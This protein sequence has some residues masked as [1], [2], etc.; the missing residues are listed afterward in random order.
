MYILQFAVIVVSNKIEPRWH[1]NCGN[2]YSKQQYVPMLHNYA[3][4]CHTLTLRKQT[5]VP[6]DGGK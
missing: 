6:V 1:K 5:Y 3:S 4:I 2:Y